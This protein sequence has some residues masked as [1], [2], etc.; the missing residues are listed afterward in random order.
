MADE[1]ELIR[2]AEVAAGMRFLDAIGRHGETIYDGR[3]I[4]LLEWLDSMVSFHVDGDASAELRDHVWNH[5]GGGV[6]T[7]EEAF[8][9]RRRTQAEPA[10]PSAAQTAF[11]D[12]ITIRDA[13]E[14][15]ESA[16]LLGLT[17]VIDGAVTAG[18]V[19]LDLRSAV[20]IFDGPVTLT[21][22]SG[23][24]V[25]RGDNAHRATSDHGAPFSATYVLASLE[26][27]IELGADVY[28]LPR[29]SAKAVLAVGERR[30]TLV[31]TWAEGAH[32]AIYGGA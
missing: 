29:G 24:I 6:E 31:D 19:R 5:G 20:P 2:A 28:C 4:I 1:P 27:R 26:T 12:G 14:P 23:W 18:G 10:P 11:L 9:W 8:A 25:R 3:A 7:D 30:W 32:A 16:A 21:L 13:L 17:E 22:P 15:H